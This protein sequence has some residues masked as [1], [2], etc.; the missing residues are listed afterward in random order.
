MF[1]E[2]EYI[3][4]RPTS[5]FGVGGFNVIRISGGSLGSLQSKGEQKVF[6]DKLVGEGRTE[7]CEKL[8]AFSRLPKGSY[9]IG[10]GDLRIS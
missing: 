9:S 3:V 5:H 1:Q 2:F 10:E 7:Q 4:L 6:G 8:D